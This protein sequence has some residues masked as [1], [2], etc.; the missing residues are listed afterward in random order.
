MET[1]PNAK[2]LKTDVSGLYNGQCEN[3]IHVNGYPNGYAK[4][5]NNISGETIDRGTQSTVHYEDAGVEFAYKLVDMIKNKELLKVASQEEAKV[6]NFKHPAELKKI[7]PLSIDA[8]GETNSSLLAV[9]QEVIEYSVRTNHTGFFNQLYHGADGY[10][11][12]A[13]WLT[14]A[15]NTSE[16]T[17][18]VAP[19]FVLVADYII[20]RLTE[21]AGYPDGDGV[22]VPGGSMGNIMS[23]A[24]ARYKHCNDVKNSGMFGMKKMVILASEDSHYSSRKGAA[25]LGF[26]MDNVISVKCDSK[27]RMCI[28]SLKECIDAEKAKGHVPL[29]VIATAGTTVLGS[30]DD[31]DS[32]ASVCKEYGLWMHV[33]ACWGGG[34]LFSPK[35][36]HLLKGI[37]HSDSFC[38]SLHKMMGASL[39][40]VP[41]L[42]RHKG[43][44]QETFGFGASYLFQ[45]DKFYDVSYDMGD[46][47]IQCG[48][49]VDAF[50]FWLMWKARGDLGLAEVVDNAFDLATWF[51]ERV[52]HSEGFRLVMTEFQYVNV[53]FWYIPKRLRNQPETE[54]WWQEVHKVAPLIKE[55]MA[56]SGTLLI[57]YQPL[58]SKNFVN[59][60]RIIIECPRLTEKDLMFVIEEIDR[61]GKDL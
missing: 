38:I 16:Y 43:L 53:G 56:L 52:Q 12:A 24:M 31:L 6:V 39:Q 46:K 8:D 45:Q 4:M 3:G 15:L 44:L 22:F 58:K 40:C 18:E 17:F 42:T 41:L 1:R 34:A 60:F 48:R 33:D 13:S 51:K 5:K 35:H 19:V 23:L 37:E 61:I 9:C 28:E 36:R 47:T 11:I 57:G 54:Q 59:F 25:F 49:K 55:K 10:S 32:I 14:E 50:K 2:R 7:L 27:G 21:I 29:V 26:G 30:F 20:N